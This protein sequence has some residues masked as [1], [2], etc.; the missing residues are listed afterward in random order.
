MMQKITK[1]NQPFNRIET[2][3]DKAKEIIKIM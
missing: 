1:E 3:Y 2:D